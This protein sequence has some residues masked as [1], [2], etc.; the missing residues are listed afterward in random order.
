MAVTTPT[1][2]DWLGLSPPAN[3]PP[4]ATPMAPIGGVAGPGYTD[5]FWNWL[6]GA[7]T[8][9]TYQSILDNPEKAQE[10]Y[11]TFVALGEPAPAGSGMATEDTATKQ[12][13][14]QDIIDAITASLA[15]IFTD[16]EIAEITNAIIA[17]VLLGEAS[18][19]DILRL[20]RGTEVYKAKFPGFLESISAHPGM[21]EADYL[22]TRDQAN[23]A[24]Q[25]FFG[26]SVTA[27]QFGELWSGDTSVKEFA[28]RLEIGKQ[29]VDMGGEVRKLFE[30]ES[31]QNLTD[32]E[33][34]EFLSNDIS[35]PKFDDIYKNA[36]YKG[37]LVNLGVDRNVTDDMVK[38]IER[39]GLT[40]EN[41]LGSYKELA[42]AL[43]ALD[44]LAGIDS[45][46]RND[47]DNPFDT[48]SQA[49][50]A[51]V[52]ANPD[53]RLAITQAFARETARW[54]SQGGASTDQQGRAVGLLSPTQ[55]QL[56]S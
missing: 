11:D 52:T 30:L 5:A 41:V 12:V 2:S 6:L 44:R 23:D 53:A 18:D 40:L 51:Y 56:F 34:Y 54:T 39:Q 28:R 42:G 46:V 27:S 35:T 26:R 20:I 50:K 7:V 22:A 24:Y 15:G 14:T 47:P 29:I 21:T 33:L 17:P 19:Q 37:Y 45:A 9:T 10:Y 4:V 36:Y 1:T 25:S 13:I 32:E 16:A 31:G 43:P 49:W 48:F 3:T 8:L 55:R 38:E